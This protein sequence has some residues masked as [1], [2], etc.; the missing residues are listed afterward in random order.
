MEGVEI[1]PNVYW[2]GA[3]D[4]NVRDFHGYHTPRGSTYNAYLILDEKVTLIDTVKAP[5]FEQLKARVGHYVDPS[6]IDVVISNH[7]EMDHSS[8]LPLLMELAPSAAIYCSKRGEAGLRRHY[9]KDWDFHTVATGH[10]LSLGR[11]SVNFVLTPMLHW[12]DSM[13]TYLPDEQILFSMDGFGQHIASSE[14]F[15]EDLGVE[16]TLLEA[17]TYWANILMPF[18]KMAIK[19]FEDLGDTPIKTICPSHGVMWRKHIPKILDA[20]WRWATHQVRRKAVIV[21]GTMWHSTEK[22]ALAIAEGLRSVGIE[23]RLFDLG[24]TD[25]TWVISEIQESAAIVVGSSTLN[26]TALPKVGEFLTYLTGLKPEGRIGAIFG[27][28]GWSRG[29]E[30]PIRKT[31]EAIKADLPLNDLLVQYVPSAEDLEKCESFGRQLAQ[32][33]DQRA[34]K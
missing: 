22:M 10:T 19:A 4:W 17:R 7:V 25:L 1:A 11:H 31:L 2:V 29:A 15:A 12:P 23:T 26:M 30:A 28:Y 8:G 14:R 27:S 24:S 20:Y 18:G 5:L 34:A 13:M 21:Y 9:G 6:K 3:I 33:I 16:T 32:A